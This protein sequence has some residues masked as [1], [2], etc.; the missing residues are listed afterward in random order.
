MKLLFK[1]QKETK[2]PA[3]KLTGFKFI[4]KEH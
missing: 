3:S 2:K 1:A 4:K